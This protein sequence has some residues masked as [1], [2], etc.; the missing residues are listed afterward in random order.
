MSSLIV[1]LFE[2]DF[3]IRSLMRGGAPWFIA[4]DVCRALHYTNTRDPIRR[5]DDDEKG[6]V[7]H[8]T[9]GGDQDMV[10]ISEPGVYRL[11]AGSRTP[12]AKRFQ[13]WLYHEVL[14]DIRRTGQYAGP[15]KAGDDVDIR[16]KEWKLEA[17]RSAHRYFGK[18]AARALWL[19]LGLPSA[20][21]FCIATPPD[22][23]GDGRAALSHILSVLSE[24]IR[25]AIEGDKAGLRR[26]GIAVKSCKCKASVHIAFNHPY[27]VRLYANTPFDDLRWSYALRRLPGAEASSTYFDDRRQRSTRLPLSLILDHLETP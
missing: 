20:D 23:S 5:L 7:K 27:L 1:H 26:T 11:I 10:I 16:E 2:D 17:V 19:Q 6:V 18:A 13:R 4:R 12:A 25:T 3:P 21:S 9:P 14:P 8:D 22:P 15:P 24:E